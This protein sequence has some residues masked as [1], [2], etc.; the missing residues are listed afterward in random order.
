MDE[1][2][3]LYLFH[4]KESKKPHTGSRKAGESFSGNISRF[5]DL[6]PRKGAVKSGAGDADIARSIGEPTDLDSGVPARDEIPPS[7]AP[8]KSQSSRVFESDS[9]DRGL[10]VWRKGLS[11]RRRLRRGGGGLSSRSMMGATSAALRLLRRRYTCFFLG[12]MSGGRRGLRTN[13]LTPGPA[14]NKIQSY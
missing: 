12:V 7:F 2:V 14:L 4:R 5:L 11:T 3:K 6:A 13:D 10:S 9:M 8:P 1:N